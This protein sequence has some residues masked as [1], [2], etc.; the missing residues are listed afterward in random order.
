MNTFILKKNTLFY[1]KCY[2]IFFN[3]N[4]YQQNSYNLF[5]R[6]RILNINPH[7]LYINHIKTEFIKD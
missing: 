7:R 6:F 3:K 1:I 2:K 5:L 4:F